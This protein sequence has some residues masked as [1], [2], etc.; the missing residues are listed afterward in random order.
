MAISLIITVAPPE[1]A[2]PA[3]AEPD[4]WA[5]AIRTLTRLSTRAKPAR[6]PRQP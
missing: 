4:A 5:E 2:M 3:P 6:T 1:D